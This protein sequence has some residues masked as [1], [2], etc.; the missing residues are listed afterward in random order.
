MLAILPVAVPHW[1]IN[2]FDKHEHAYWLHDE[3]SPDI[4][5]SCVRPGFFTSPLALQV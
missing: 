3:P 4:Y 5:Q 1:S 2:V